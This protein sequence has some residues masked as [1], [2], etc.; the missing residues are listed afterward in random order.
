[1]SIELERSRGRLKAAKT[2]IDELRGKL[3]I[4]DSKL[5]ALS[6]LKIESEKELATLDLENKGE[7]ELRKIIAECK[8]EERKAKEECEIIR[9]KFEALERSLFQTEEERSGAE[10]DSHQLSRRVRFK[11]ITES[12]GPKTERTRRTADEKGKVLETNLRKAKLEMK[13]I[14]TESKLNLELAMI[15]AIEPYK[16]NIQ[17]LKRTIA[18]LETKLDQSASELQQ[19][20]DSLPKQE[21]QKQKQAVSEQQPSGTMSLTQQH[22][23]QPQQQHHQSLG[24]RTVQSAGSPMARKISAAAAEIAAASA[25]AVVKQMEIFAKPE[26]QHEDS[27]QKQQQ[28][29]QQQNQQPNIF[30]QSAMSSSSMSEYDKGLQDIQDTLRKARAA[31]AAAKN[32][33]S[34]LE[35]DRSFRSTTRSEEAPLGASTKAVPRV[36]PISGLQLKLRSPEKSRRRQSDNKHRRKN[37]GGKAATFTS[38]DPRRESSPSPQNDEERSIEEGQQSSTDS[39]LSLWQLDRSRRSGIDANPTDFSPGNTRGLEPQTFSGVEVFVP[40]DNDFQM[41]DKSPMHRTVDGAAADVV[42]TP[43]AATGGGASVGIMD[44]SKAWK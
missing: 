12:P 35:R 39:R 3:E 20:R 5:A 22:Q 29:Q 26:E 17:S 30:S 33:V 36:P 8:L 13:E 15:D 37:D 7:E 9:G 40:D 24:R 43:T 34:E 1:M 41:P 6:S 23:Q 4:A 42:G 25:A 2:Q 28:Q 18:G 38:F 14:E 16:R 31:Q 27:Q 21:Q 11:D 32:V 44:E 19:Y 10:A